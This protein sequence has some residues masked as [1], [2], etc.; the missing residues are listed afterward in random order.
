[1]RI[2][3]VHIEHFRSIKAV[4]FEPGSLCVL[5]GENNAGKSNI[6][7]AL[8][9]LLGESWPTERSFSDDDFHGLDTTKDIVIQAF[10]EDETEVWRNQHKMKVAGI[11]LRCHAYL[12]KTGTKQ[13]GDLKVE[14]QCINAKGEPC[15][16]PAEPKKFQGQWMELRVSGDLRE[17][18]PLIY[19][20]VL[21]NYDRH[22]AGNRWSILRRLLNDVNV[23]FANDTRLIPVTLPDGSK[24]KMT[25]RQAFERAVKDAYTY[26]RTDTFVKLEELVAKN[27]LEQMGV[28]PSEGGVSLHFESH[29]PSHVY[30]ALELYI[31]EMGIESPAGEV[32]SGLQSA[33]VVGIFRTYEEM[34]KG[35]AIF[36]V[37]EPEVFLHPQKARYFAGVLTRLAD[38]GNQVML[39]THSPVFV[40]LDRPESVA[41]VRRTADKGTWVRKPA[42]VDLAATERQALRLMT[43]FDAQRNELFFAKRVMFV[44]GMTEKMALPLAFRA[45][46]VDVNREGVS[47][48]ECGGKT[49]VPLFIRVAAALEIPYVVLADDDIREIKEE[50][51][52][53]RRRQEEERNR[54]HRQWNSELAKLADA[55]RLFFLK[56]DFEHELGLPE[57]EDE[58]IDNALKRFAAAQGTDVP[59]C[60]KIPIERL[61]AGNH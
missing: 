43:E 16:Y 45:L 28:L 57:S 20:D 55:D 26:L 27:T 7:R 41:V 38:Q 1:M 35:G 47:I 23:E 50:W 2:A 29:D 12:K 34:K 36:V 4:D 51:G 31:D 15:K 5:I 53:T 52:E 61:M 10:F 40:Q 39:S 32:G 58:K 48:V 13:R 11:E 37:E 56:P 54:K 18:T 21:R 44:E 3:R 49:K 19:V 42:K 8:S 22:N 25:R 6:L 14:Y 17:Q 60:L 33:I 46:G 30:R 24:S 9:L 59:A